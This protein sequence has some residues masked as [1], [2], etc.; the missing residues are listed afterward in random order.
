MKENI[1]EELHS[2]L[3]SNLLFSSPILSGNM[4]SNIHT[5]MQGTNT[6]EIVIEAPFYDIKKWQKE[7]VVVHTGKTEDG[8]TDYAWLVNKFGAFGSHNKSEGWVNRAIMEVVETI[9]N[10]I[11]AQVINDLQL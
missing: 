6:R 9:A 3:Y 1:I 5:G 7:H 10:K 4:I 2:L 11:G 8:F